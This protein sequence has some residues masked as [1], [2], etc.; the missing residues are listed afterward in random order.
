VNIRRV[1]NHN[2]L[3]QVLLYVIA[4][5]SLSKCA[6]IELKAFPIDDR[7]VVLQP[8]PTDDRAK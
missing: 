2:R 4:I 3:L 6:S 7:L 8:D 5:N 1:E